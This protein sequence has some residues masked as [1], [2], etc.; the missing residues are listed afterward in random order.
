MIALVSSSQAWNFVWETTIHH[1][2][3]PEDQPEEENATRL[4]EFEVTEASEQKEDVVGTPG[5]TIAV[6][7]MLLPQ[8]RDRANSQV[9]LVPGEQKTTLLVVRNE[10]EQ[11]EVEHFDSNVSPMNLKKMIESKDCP[12]RL[13]NLSPIDLEALA[14]NGLRSQ[15]RNIFAKYDGRVRELNSERS[16]REGA[17]KRHIDEKI[18]RD[19]PKIQEEIQ[20]LVRRKYDEHYPSLKLGFDVAHGPE[21]SALLHQRYAGLSKVGDDVVRKHKPD[22][23]SDREFQSLKGKW[24]SVKGYL[25]RNPN[26]SEAEHGDFINNILNGTYDQANARAILRTSLW[27]PFH[28][29]SSLQTSPQ[30]FSSWGSGDPSNATTNLRSTPTLSSYPTTRISDIEFVSQLQT[31]QQAHP[32]LSGLVQKVHDAL[33]RNLE[34]LQKKVVAD[35]LDRIVSMERQRQNNAAAGARENEYREGLRREFEVVLRE[36]REAMVS[37]A[38]RMRHVDW[39]RSTRGGQ[40]HGQ[41]FSGNAQFRWGGRITSLRPAQNRHSIYPLEL[42][43][44][45]SQLCRVD[46]AHVPQPKVDARHKFE[47]S[48]LKG[49]SVEFMQLV[50]DKCLAVVSERGRTRIFIEDNVT[51]DHAVN[52]TRGKVSLSHDLLGG[53][54]C[55]FAFDQTTRLLAIVHGNEDDLQL[56]IYIFDETFTNLR[57]RGSPISLKDWCDNRPV[58]LSKVLFVSGVEEVCLVETSGRVRIFSLIAQQ[59]R[60]PFLQV[61]R[62]IIDAFSA[63]DGSCL[64]VIVPGNQSTSHCLLAF[65]WASFG[66]NRRGIDSTSLDPCDGYRVATRFDGRGR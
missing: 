39:I 2:D 9:R 22:V 17:D 8:G 37:S 31:T 16:R 18:I 28:P 13:G 40:S 49:R 57:S 48:L 60:T 21:V 3:A 30:N 14:A 44:Q 35:Q 63:P 47:F 38:R 56:S 59:F 54:Q 50:C 66:N 4:F 34:A 53:P 15:H 65:D 6:E 41:R 33:G 12:L 46:E 5:F 45:D 51:I 42:T 36:L 27:S 32:A 10:Q 11:T 61:D 1:E 19:R 24:G 52:A 62:P 26:Q 43:E 58:D 25:E 7:S 64:L 55:K 20:H 23:V 29:L